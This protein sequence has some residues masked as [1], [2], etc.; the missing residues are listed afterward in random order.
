MKGW[1]R[2][3]NCTGNTSRPDSSSGRTSQHESS[4]QQNPRLR[5]GPRNHPG[6]RKA[7]GPDNQTGTILEE[8]VS[9]LNA[10]GATVTLSLD[11]VAE[12]S[13]GIPDR[14][15]TIIQKNTGDLKFSQS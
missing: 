14:E 3:D 4:S 7:P 10:T 15:R 2:A 9:H 6:K 13:T 11:I 8:V 12:H 5:A 1:W